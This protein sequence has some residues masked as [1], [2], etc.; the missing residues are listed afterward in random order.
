ML[1]LFL[2]Y[3]DFMEGKEYLAAIAAF[4]KINTANWQKLFGYFPSLKEAWHAKT[5][6]L[7]QAGLTQD[8]AADFSGYRSE[9]EPG[10]EL[11][12]LRKHK[13]E[14]I[15]IADEI[16]PKNLKEIYTPPVVLYLKGK[17]EERDEN[18]IAIVGSRKA[19]DYGKRAT[20]DIAT[21]LAKSG[22]TIISG[23]AL[24]LDAEAHLAAVENGAR[25]IAVLANGLDAIYPV[26]NQGLANRILENGAIISEQPIGMPPLKQNFPARNR[27]ISGLSTGVLVTEAGEHSGTLHTANFALEQNRQIYAVPGPIYNPLAQG[28]NNLL[29]MGAKAVTCAADILED[30]GIEE[31]LAEKPVPENQEEVIIFE[32]LSDEPKHIDTITQIIDKPVAE[33]SQLLT[34]MEIKGKVKHLGGMVYTL[35]K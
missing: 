18:A 10:K 13:V 23:L 5:G 21:G 8:F 26:S 4:P 3:T 16:Y 28:P 11:E 6:D 15:T 32:V 12:K 24:G 34:M 22:I 33:V 7:I 27:I 25:T 2:V 31:E 9:T 19:T 29:K 17:L 30:L 20:K 35:R 14:I 1:N